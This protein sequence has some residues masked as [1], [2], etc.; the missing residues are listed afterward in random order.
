M[1]TQL[2]TLVADGELHI[3]QSYSQ[4][5]QNAGYQVITAVDADDALEQLG[6]NTVHIVV[7]DLHFC[8]KSLTGLDILREARRLQPNCE[9]IFVTA[10]PNL[11]TAIE[12]LREGACD[13]LTKPVKEG[14]LLESIGRAQEKLRQRLQRHDALMTIENSLRMVLGRTVMDVATPL[15]FITAPSEQYQVGPV[16]LDLDRHVIEVEGRQISATSSEIQ[17]LACLCRNPQRVI[18]PQE[19]IRSIR[20]YAVGQRDAQEM[21]RSHISNLRRKLVAA[22]RQAD[23]IATVRSAGYTLK[24]SPRRAP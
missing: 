9:V 16:T 15:E 3:R 4:L 1:G 20:G 5:L 11:E 14:T 22:S 23:V 21:V 10:S 13:Y 2:M 12:A 7:S 8:D 17:I 18:S 19:I 24:T 6:T